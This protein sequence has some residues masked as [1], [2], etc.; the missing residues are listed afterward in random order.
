MGIKQAGALIPEGAG[1]PC[2]QS[3][4]PTPTLLIFKHPS[5][6]CSLPK[7][8]PPSCS[9]LPHD[10]T[11][12]QNKLNVLKLSCINR[13]KLAYVQSFKCKP[14]VNP[15]MVHPF[16]SQGLREQGLTQP[17]LPCCLLPFST[18]KLGLLC[19]CQ[20]TLLC[21]KKEHLYTILRLWN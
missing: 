5:L 12:A 10:E 15:A 13:R 1:C 7:E 21:I 3:I 19:S 8:I 2:G 14:D 6:R 4:P 20:P 9:F 16:Q 11:K 18:Q 17:C